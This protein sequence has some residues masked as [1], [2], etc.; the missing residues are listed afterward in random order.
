LTS[1]GKKI[2][3]GVTAEVF[4]YGDGRVLKLARPGIERWVLEHEARTTQA[5]FESGAPAPQVFEVVE[6]D[7]RIG[8]V[9]PRYEGETLLAKLIRGSVTPSQVGETMARVH[10][11]LHAGAYQGDLVPFHAFVTRW[12]RGLEE[13]GIEP[14][15][16]SIATK[17]LDELPRSGAV[18]HGDLHSDN[19][20]MTADGPVILDWLSAVSADPMVD[21]ARQHLSL[22]ILP[23]EDPRPFA[24]TYDEMR[25]QIHSAFLGTYSELAG[26]TVETLLERIRPF[27][28]VMAALRLAEPTRTPLE[29]EILTAFIRGSA[30][31]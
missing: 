19:I 7:G 6:H 2:G 23:V 17:V 18:C 28:P 27:V 14:D 22:T 16:V 1:P 24:K 20:L 26:T 9:Y 10:H 12:L 29:I 11:G 21:L 30:N 8:I 31:K 3:Q 13:K 15:V 4:E 25:P 5:A